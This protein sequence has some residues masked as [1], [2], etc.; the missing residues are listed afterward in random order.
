MTIAYV[1]HPS[2]ISDDGAYRAV[3]RPARTY[4]L[5]EVVD[6]ICD[7]GSTVSEADVRAVLANLTK[8]IRMAL[9]DGCNVITPFANFGFSIR[10]K[11]EGAEDRF[12]A[13]RHRVEAQAR[14]GAVIR[15]ALRLRAR[16]VKLEALSPSPT[17]LHYTD[18]ISATHNRTLTPGGP[19]KLFGYRLS[20][21]PNDPAQGVFFVAGNRSETRAGLLVEN[22]PQ[23]LI[24]VV[25]P[26]DTGE[27]TLEVRSTIDGAGPLRCGTLS[28]KLRV[29]EE[30]P[31]A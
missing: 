20:F 27:Y 28:P 4:D 12:D 25:P 31:P 2:R 29:P 6:Q 1:L 22:L 13:S 8:V 10:G 18:V 14:P 16:T 30:I 7:L 9:L 19:G 15:R 5:D 3:A 21:D 26:L 17:P 11:F 24:F 23:T